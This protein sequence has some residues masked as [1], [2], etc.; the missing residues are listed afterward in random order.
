MLLVDQD[1]PV[2]RLA[3]LERLE[4]LVGLCQGPVVDPS[5]DTLLIR[6]L[7]HLADL[8]GSSNKTASNLDTLANQGKLKSGQNCFGFLRG[9]A[10]LTAFREGKTSSGAPTWIK[11]PKVRRR[12]R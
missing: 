2:S 10:G 11:V 3:S 12:R 9:G 6:Q 4:S 1:D 8:L 7:D 5:L